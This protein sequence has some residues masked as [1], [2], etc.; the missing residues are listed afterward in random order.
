MKINKRKNVN[1]Y[2]FDFNNTYTMEY[3]DVRRFLNF[4]LYYCFYHCSSW[5]TLIKVTENVTSKSGS[6]VKKVEDHCICYTITYIDYSRRF[7]TMRFMLGQCMGMSSTFFFFVRFQTLME[8]G[9][10]YSYKR[11][12]NFLSMRI[13]NVLKQ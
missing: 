5:L 7:Y 4:F 1:C 6:L 12:C 8:V 10:D 11:F 13:H 9:L 3:L 2:L